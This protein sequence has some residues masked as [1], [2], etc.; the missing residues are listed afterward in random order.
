MIGMSTIATIRELYRNGASIAHIARKEGISEP[1]VRKYLAIKDFSP[2][3]PQPRKARP[4]ILD[5]YKPLIDEWLDEDKRSWRKQRHTATRI[6][7]R[8]K[9]ET[10]Y[11]GKYTTV[12]IYVR[13]RREETGQDKAGYLDLV[14]EPAEAQLDFGQ[15]DFRARGVTTRLHYLVMTFPFSNVG[16]AQLF[17]GENAECVCEGLASIFA[18]VGG[19]PKRVVFDNATGVGRRVCDCVRTT[20]LFARCAAHFGFSYSFCN[21]A[22]G[23]E[24]GS[25]EN[26]VGFIRRNLFVPTVALDNVQAYNKRL[27]DRSYA[28]S[29]RPH[30]RKQEN[31]LRLFA[32]DTA[33][34]YELPAHA[35]RA[36]TQTSVKADKKG[37]I[38]LDGRHL[39]SADPALAGQR[40]DVE[41]GAFDVAIYNKGA[42]VAR[43]PRAYGKHPTDTSDPASQLACLCRKPGGWQ[44]SQVRASLEEDVRTFIDDLDHEGR[45]GVLS[46]MRSVSGTYGYAA[47]SK[48]LSDSLKAT[49]A[50]PKSDVTLLASLAARG[51]DVV[52][53]DDT[54]SMDAYDA[55]L[56]GARP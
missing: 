28:L 54:W 34:L 1:T 18:Y 51:R 49:G 9:E 19:V 41:L 45:K 5:P 36:V 25:V 8:L 2:A 10:G 47:M 43:H 52:R 39:Y 44:N 56:T 26:K 53:Y 38:L 32:E 46:M 27:L 7:N 35:F 20:E 14:W 30:Y 6:Y 48:A 24:K 55:C 33:A 22:S 17:L 11:S 40:L 29:D 12:Q 16:L 42:L 37:R 50:L 31:C 21:P 13:R 3:V 15:A 23:N 4:S